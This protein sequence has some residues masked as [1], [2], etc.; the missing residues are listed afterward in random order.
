MTV[1]MIVCGTRGLGGIKKALLGS[2]STYLAE[3]ATCTCIVTK[4]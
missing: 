1:N 2:V 3:H 4:K